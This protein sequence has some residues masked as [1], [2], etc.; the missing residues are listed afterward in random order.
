MS[1]KQSEVWGTAIRGDG[2]EVVSEIKSDATKEGRS[3]RGPRTGTV[4]DIER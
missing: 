2:D 3:N 1:P 4:G